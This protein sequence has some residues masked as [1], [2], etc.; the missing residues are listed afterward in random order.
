[1][2]DAEL[3]KAIEVAGETIYGGFEEDYSFEYLLSSAVLE[4]ASRLNVEL[5]AYTNLMEEVE[6]IKAST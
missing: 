5:E 2:N 3:N 6:L 4:L 1:M